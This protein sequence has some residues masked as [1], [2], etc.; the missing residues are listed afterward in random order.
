MMGRWGSHTG[1]PES[2]ILS[3][4]NQVIRLQ[5]VSVGSLNNSIVHPREVFRPAIA[6]GAASLI[7]VHN[8]PS[9]DVEPSVDDVALTN[10]L[11]EAGSLLGIEVL[12]HVI[13]GGNGSSAYRSMKTA[14][15]PFSSSGGSP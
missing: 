13:L 10:R 15:H 11:V 12:D 9:G 4:R 5:V 8:H 14:G 6:A 7:L 3:A 1:Y 2:G